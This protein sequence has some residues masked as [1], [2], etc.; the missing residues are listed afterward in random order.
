MT[1]FKKYVFL[2]A[3]LVLTAA[4]T[5]GA[6]LYSY[7]FREHFTIGGEWLIPGVVAAVLA[8]GREVKRLQ[9][10]VKGEF[11]HERNKRGNH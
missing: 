11:Y 10:I 4:A 9:K 3:V 8:V 7:R 6:V 5:T 2:V 1:R